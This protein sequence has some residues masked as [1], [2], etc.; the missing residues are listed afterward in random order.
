MP[1]ECNELAVGSV[2]GIFCPELRYLFHTEQIRQV[3]TNFSDN[4]I[5]TE[6]KF[7][8]IQVYSFSK[9]VDFEGSMILLLNGSEVWRVTAAH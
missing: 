4:L 3:T 9:E 6:E 5:L 8:D 7:S 1:L 2:T